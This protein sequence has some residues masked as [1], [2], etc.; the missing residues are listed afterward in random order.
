MAKYQSRNAR[1]VVVEEQDR[2][3]EQ[4]IL[5]GNNESFLVPK[6][7]FFIDYVEAVSGTTVTLTDGNGQTIVSSLSS[8]SQEYSPL[9]CEGGVTI[10]G[11]VVMVKGFVLR[12]VFE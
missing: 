4:V 11:N 2:Y 12:Q 5:T 6:G 7:V 3:N 9:K 8:Y 10:T 1:K